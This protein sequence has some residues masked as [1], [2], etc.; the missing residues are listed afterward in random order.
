[1]IPLNLK[2]TAVTFAFFGCDGVHLVPSFKEFAVLFRQINPVSLFHVEMRSG[3]D[4]AGF[5]AGLCFF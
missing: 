5:F 1:M 2:N 3:N 4:S